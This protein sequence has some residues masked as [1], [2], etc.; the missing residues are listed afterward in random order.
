MTSVCA[1]VSDLPLEI[2]RN[3]LRLANRIGRAHRTLYIIRP[4]GG[5]KGGLYAQLYEITR[6]RGRALPVITPINSGFLRTR[7]AR[8]IIVCH[9]I[10]SV[11]RFVACMPRRPD[12]QSYSV[13]S[14]KNKNNDKYEKAMPARPP[15]VYY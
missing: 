5:T 10:L 15:R 14:G 6:V 9:D 7:R 11:F 13:C 2:Q 4:R 3:P 12:A 8:V 1:H